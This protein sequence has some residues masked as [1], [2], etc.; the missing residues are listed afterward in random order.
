M[1]RNKKYIGDIIFESL[2]DPAKI[3]FIERYCIKERFEDRPSEYIKK[4]NIKRYKINHETLVQLIPI[5]ENNFADGEWYIHFYSEKTNEM[6]VIF[7]DR[8]FLISKYKDTSWDKMIAYGE[9][10]GVGRRWTE[11]IPVDFTE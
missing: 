10:L 3:D 8:C 2:K 7:K 5:L 4:W 11:N 9:K 1:K 6:Y